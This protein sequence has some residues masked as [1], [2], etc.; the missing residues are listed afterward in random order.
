MRNFSSEGGEGGKIEDL[1]ED[2]SRLS[3]DWENSKKEASKG[4]HIFDTGSP[5][6]SLKDIYPNINFLQLKAK[7]ITEDYQQALKICISDEFSTFQSQWYF[8][9]F[10]VTA[11]LFFSEL[12]C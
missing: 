1:L 8:F 11:F 5:N 9:L 12:C 6:N 3:R 7:S 10:H 4:I 2:I